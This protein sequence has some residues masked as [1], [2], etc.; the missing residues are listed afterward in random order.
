MTGYKAFYSDL[1]YQQ[2]DSNGQS[3]NG[4][5]LSHSKPTSGTSTRGFVLT[6]N[7]QP[8]YG[9]SGEVTFFT[10]PSA[11]PSQAAWGTQ[12]ADYHPYN[13]LH[14]YGQLVYDSDNQGNFGFAMV[15]GNFLC[16]ASHTTAYSPCTLNKMRFWDASGGE[17]YTYTRGVITLLK[18]G[19]VEE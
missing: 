10:G 2:F 15:G 17:R 9:L 3:Q 8:G 1:A 16:D 6:H 18:M 11:D 12:H 5:H 7:F 13:A 19:S 4:H 14:V